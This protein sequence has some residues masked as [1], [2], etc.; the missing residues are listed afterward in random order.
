MAKASRNA[1]T[2]R[3][4]RYAYTFHCIF[5]KIKRGGRDEREMERKYFSKPDKNASSFRFYPI[6]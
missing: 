2:F 3:L 4:A 6:V 1:A 5:D